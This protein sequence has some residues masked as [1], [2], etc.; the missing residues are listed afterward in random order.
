M[1]IKV[2]GT[3]VIDET[4]LA[5]INMSNLSETGQNVIKGLVSGQGYMKRPD[6]TNASQKTIS[7]TCTVHKSNT[8]ITNISYTSFSVSSIGYLS[9]SSLPS[10]YSSNIQISDQIIK[11]NNK[12]VP[13]DVLKS[14]LV[15]V[16]AN[17]TVT[18]TA[19]LSGYGSSYGSDITITFTIA[20]FMFYPES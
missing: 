4:L 15:P 10:T 1:P 18:F 12:V 6:Y 19:T 17:D 13:N 16:S 20:E 8:S 11:I 3:T 5:D 14:S 2:N 7:C 9:I